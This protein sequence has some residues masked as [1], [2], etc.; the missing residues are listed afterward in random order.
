[1]SNQEQ[2]EQEAVVLLANELAVEV[3]ETDVEINRGWT[4]RTG[5]WDQIP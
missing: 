3:D 5:T 4:L 1:M 2:M